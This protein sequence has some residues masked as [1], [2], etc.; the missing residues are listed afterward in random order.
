[1][2]KMMT[3]VALMCAVT[4]Q[5]N[6]QNSDEQLQK[7]ALEVVLEAAKE[8]DANPTD[9][10]K[11]YVAAA[12]FNMDLLCDKVD[13]DRALAYAN[14]ALQIAESQTVLKDTLMGHT[15]L[16]LGS[17]YLKKRELEKAYDFYEKGLKAFEQELGRYDP[18]TICQKLKIGFDIMM[19]I[20]VRYGS[21]FIQQAFLDSER[22]PVE[23]RL[24]NMTEIMAL[25]DLAIEFLVADISNKMWNGLPIVFFEGKR[26]FMVET[27]EW[28]MEQPV[29]GWLVPKLRL[30]LQGKDAKKEGDIVLIETDDRNATPRIIKSDATVK[31]Q[32]EVNFSQDANDEHAL[33]V[34]AESARLM[35]VYGTGYHEIL[36]KYREFKAGK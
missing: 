21:L 17:I 9:G 20:D 10:R 26:Y 27:P 34:P 28:N 33:S 6:A 18:V 13:L 36:A 12:G 3:I 25:Y 30:A 15:C 19:S 16:T 8:A 35:F 1:M 11:Q 22:V 4:F 7:K 5:V 31:P 23:K 2:K 24:K 32:F 14:K 29:V